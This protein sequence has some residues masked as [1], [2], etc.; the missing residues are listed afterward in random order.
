VPD[1]PFPFLFLCPPLLASNKHVRFFPPA[2]PP[3]SG[4]FIFL[5]FRR[6]DSSLNSFDA[7][8]WP[9]SSSFLENQ[10]CR[11]ELSQTRR[12]LDF[13]HSSMLGDTPLTLFS[14]FEISSPFLSPSAPFPEPLVSARLLFVLMFCPPPYRILTF[15]FGSSLS[16]IARPAFPSQGT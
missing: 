13:P 11:A 12:S 2:A 14:C 16:R 15:F 3:H 6:L 4:K 8:S 1:P 9:H 5:P 10:F 7:E